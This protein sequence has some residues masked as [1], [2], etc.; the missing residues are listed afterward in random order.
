MPD[1]RLGVLDFGAVKQLSEPFAKAHRELY[2]QVLDGVLPNAIELLLQAGFEINVPHAQL[3]PLIQQ[4]FEV[5]RRPV[6]SSFYDFASDQMTPD[7]RVIGR[8]NF[9]I[10]FGVRPP[11]EAI[12]FFRAIFGNSQN[13]RA[14]QAAGDFRACYQRILDIAGT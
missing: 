3:A 5:L 10:F 4:V 1:G 11:P 12:Q 2:R 8:A 7:L 9:K 14:L 13:L 6:A